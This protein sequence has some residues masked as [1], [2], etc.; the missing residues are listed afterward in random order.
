MKLD[1]DLAG[2]ESA[3]KTWLKDAPWRSQEDGRESKQKKR[4]Q[5][6]G[7]P[8]SPDSPEALNNVHKETLAKSSKS[9]GSIRGK[10]KKSQH[11]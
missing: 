2:T 8:E 5:R 1:S 3:V 4:K 9:G 11:E 7:S 10:A 6:D